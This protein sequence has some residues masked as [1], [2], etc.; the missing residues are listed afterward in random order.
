MTSIEMYGMPSPD[1]Q[2]EEE[3]DIDDPNLTYVTGDEMLSL[4]SNRAMYNHRLLR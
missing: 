3:E 2:I 4:L 1:D